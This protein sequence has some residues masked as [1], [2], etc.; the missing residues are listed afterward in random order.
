MIPISPHLS[1]KITLFSFVSIVLVVFIHARTWGLM[2]PESGV[3]Y[4]VNAYVQNFI[5][6]GI[7]R[8]AVPLFFAFSGFLFFATVEP[9]VAS[10]RRKLAARAKSLAVPYLLWN[11]LGILLI[12]VMQALHGNTPFNGEKL[13]RDYGLIDYLSRL[14]PHPVQFQFW[15]LLDLAVYFIFSPLLYMLIRK[16]GALV[17]LLFA[18]LYF[19]KICKVYLPICDA[20]LHPEGM[21][22]FALGAWLAIKRVKIPE[23]GKATTFTA[24]A[25]W[26]VLCIVKAWLLVKIGETY[27]YNILHRI[28][29]IAGVWCVW[30]LYDFLPQRLIDAKTWTAL[31]SGTFF[32]YAFH[33]PMQ[34]IIRNE[35]LHRITN[36]PG[37]LSLCY[38]LCPVVTIALSIMLTA[39]LQRYARPFFGLLTGGRAARMVA[40][41]KT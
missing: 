8:V 17:P 2:T 10:F 24:T 6:E 16:T 40:P 29:V 20:A 23:M 12:L 34:T 41:A 1:R 21:L 14:Y 32:L 26:L 35:L 38:V 3:F 5:G 36:G 28:T 31:A 33:E 7:A 19:S 9:T 22:F 11:G 13:I 39:L 15:F 27:P 37:I 4:Y 25:V 18:V 30:R